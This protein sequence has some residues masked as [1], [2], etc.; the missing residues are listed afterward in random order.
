MSGVRVSTKSYGEYHFVPVEKGVCASRSGRIII[1]GQPV[2]GGKGGGTAFLDEKLSHLPQS[3]FCIPRSIIIGSGFFPFLPREIKPEIA[4]IDAKLLT[5]SRISQL[6]D[7]LKRYLRGPIAIRSSGQVE[8][9]GGSVAAGIFETEFD[10]GELYTTKDRERFVA[11]LLNVLNSAFARKAQPYWERQGY[12]R[13]PQIP[14]LIQEV[15]GR[16]WEFAPEYFCP[17]LAGIINT[18]IRNARM[19][20]TVLGLGVA[21]VSDSGAG[22][23]H[24]LPKVSA[25]RKIDPR[26]LSVEGELNTGGIYVVN[27]KTGNQEYLS[28]PRAAALFPPLYV[29]T[30]EKRF[31][32]MQ[33]ELG[34]FARFLEEAST[35]RRPYDIEY[36]VNNGNIVITQAR[37][38]LERRPLVKPKE[39]ILFETTDLIGYVDSR[40]FDSII[41]IKGDVLPSTDTI[42]ELMKR[43]PNS[44]LVLDVYVMYTLT[45]TEMEREIVPYTNAILIIDRNAAGHKAGT[46][47]QHF[48]LNL[49]NE[50]KALLYSANDNFIEGI[51]KKAEG[52]ERLD[53]GFSG[54]D[55]TVYRFNPPVVLAADDVSGW[56]ALH[57]YR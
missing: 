23:L 52:V 22:L 38:V 34:E 19:V 3:R 11:K 12:S 56:G 45:S 29:Q 16:Q 4:P 41:R 39:R 21:A 20:A 50:Q 24:K 2:I 43:Y 10:S 36:A 54:A 7:I 27:T 25:D 46:G 35:P 1:A 31:P 32:N 49:A 30:L 6:F 26:H 42:K 55:T 37:P 40:K 8:D 47:I 18:S 9:L 5:P 14:V 28:G 15:V 17:E 13:I 57:T 53:L 44:L 33:L 51:R 48:N